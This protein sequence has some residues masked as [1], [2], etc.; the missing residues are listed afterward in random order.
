MP[1]TKSSNH[2]IDK[3]VELVRRNPLLYDNSKDDHKDQ[4]KVE[5][6][7]CLAKIMDIYD[8]TG[9]IYFNKAITNESELNGHIWY[10]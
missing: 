6:A 4:Q 2:E 1:R 9:K 10:V 5:N 3:L 8:V 7:W